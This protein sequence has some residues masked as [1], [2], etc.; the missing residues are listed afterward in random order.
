ML[1]KPDFIKKKLVLVFATNGEK[2]SCRNDNIVIVD[3]DGNMK[4]QQTCYSLFAIFVI[5][6]ISITTGLIQKSKKFNFSIMCF[7]MGFKLYASINFALTGNTLLRKKQYET[8]KS[9]A[10]SNKIVM[11]KIQNQCEIL[12]RLRNKDTKESI[13]NLNTA[14]SKLQKLH[15]N[16]CQLNEIMGVEGLTA[17]IYFNQLFKDL[18]WKGRK[19]RIKR[20]EINLLLDI[21][22]TVLFN[23]VEALLNIYGFDVFK[24]NLHQEFFCRKSLV[25]D[26]VEPF[27]PIIDYKIKKMIKLGQTKNYN[28]IVDKEQLSLGWRDSSNF[29]KGILDEIVKHQELMF[30]YIQKYYRWFMSNQ[31][32]DLFPQ[33]SLDVNN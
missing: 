22:Y 12:K 31:N 17:K 19:P 4:L 28:Y 33:V 10:I 3:K 5:G 9:I 2:I 14:I 13:E 30:V 27:R 6:N 23:Y 18:G 20:D 26:M 8:E 29:I 1:A 15:I 32:M 11:N 24:G 25:C 21:G 7:S 16:Q